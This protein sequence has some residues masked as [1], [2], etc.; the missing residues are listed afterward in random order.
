[1]PL[2][3]SAGL[4]PK[5]VVAALVGSVAGG[6]AGVWSLGRPASANTAAPIVT[7]LGGYSTLYLTS[8]IVGLIGALLVYQIKSVR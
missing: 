5:A 3:S 4:L 8:A 6:S 1:M 7:Q 2:E